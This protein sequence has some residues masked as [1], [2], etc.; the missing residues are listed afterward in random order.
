MAD[1]QDLQD[2]EDIEVEKVEKPLQKLKIKK[3]EK[4]MTEDAVISEEPQTKQKKPRS[5]KQLEVFNKRAKGKTSTG[6]YGAEK[7]N[8]RKNSQKSG[9]N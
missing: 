8:R 3:G 5:E 1:L 7:T 9:C 6:R 2:L 4:P